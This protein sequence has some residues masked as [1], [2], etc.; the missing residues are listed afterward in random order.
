MRALVIGVSGQVGAALVKA[1]RERG[2]EAIGTY[3]THEV[4]DATPLDVRDEAQTEHLVAYAKPDWILCAGGL[5]HVDRCEDEPET[6]FG[7]NRDGP[8]HLARMGQRYGAGFVYY[9]TDYVFDGTAGPY[10]EDD[11]PKPLSVYGRS[12]AEGERAVLDAVR[13]SLVIR[14]SVVY[15]VERQEKNFV[16]QLLRS[17]RGDRKLRP[18]S[19]QRTNPTYSPDLAAANVE[20]CEREMT[21]IWHLAGA[22]VMDRL[23]F[24]R[25]VLG[26]WGMEDGWL[27]PVKTAE[28]RQKAVR[29]LNGGLRIEK[30]QAALRTQLR[31][32]REGL[33]A[34]RGA[35]DATPG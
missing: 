34:M 30:A 22:Q 10:G 18:A 23:E 15:G 3:A 29:P 28:L 9:S 19:D 26:A 6:A 16:Y 33:A 24:S 21:G 7:V 12:K 4:P 20:L 5:T 14:T 27:Q 8:L 25:L 35:L 11:P 32:P 31:G 2:H 13:R 17:A 1:L